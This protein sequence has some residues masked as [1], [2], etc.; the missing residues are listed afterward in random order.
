MKN[1]GSNASCHR[2]SDINTGLWGMNPGR[3]RCAAIKRRG[4]SELLPRKCGTDEPT[5][6]YPTYYRRFSLVKLSNYHFSGKS[7][8]SAWKDMRTGMTRKDGWGRAT[9]DYSARITSMESLPRTRD[10]GSIG[11]SD[12]TSC[13]L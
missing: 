8:H 10:T 12:W 1:A 5:A 2:I 11:V 9:I 6:H 7:A 3:V 4:T 13:Q